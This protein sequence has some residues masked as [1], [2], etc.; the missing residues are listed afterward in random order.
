MRRRV[1]VCGAGQSEADEVEER[2]DRVDDEERGQ[3]MAST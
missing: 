3:G 2:G 1:E